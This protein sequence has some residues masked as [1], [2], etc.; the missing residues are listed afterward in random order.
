M[1]HNTPTGELVQPPLTAPDT[2]AAMIPPLKEQG[3]DPEF[4]R[5]TEGDYIFPDRTVDLS[6]RKAMYGRVTTR[7]GTIMSRRGVTGGVSVV[8]SAGRGELFGN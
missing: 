6:P 1:I 5:N 4:N 2:E 3:T 7:P 8:Y